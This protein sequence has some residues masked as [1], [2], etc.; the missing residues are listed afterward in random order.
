MIKNSYICKIK[1]ELLI[2]SSMFLFI[3]CH[4]FLSITILV[5]ICL[6]IWTAI[7]WDTWFHNPEEASYN[8]PDQPSWVLLTPGND[9]ELSRNVSWICGDTLAHSFLQLMG[10][11]I[12]DTLTIN[13]IGEVFESCS[14]KAAYYHARLDSLISGGHYIYSVV[15]GGTQSEWFY[16]QMPETD[17]EHFSFVYVGDVQDTIDVQANKFIKEAFSRNSDAEMLVCGGDLTERPT[18]SYW[19]ETFRDIDSIAQ[20]VPVLNITGNHDYLKGVICTLERRF[21]LVFSY[22]LHSKVDDNMVYTTTF[23]P[24]QFF[25][26]DSNREFFYLSKQKS[27]L[28]NELEASTS[29]WK[30]LLIHHPLQSAKGNNMIQKWMFDEL[31]ND[32]GIDLVLQAHEHCYARMT[33]KTERGTPTT[34]VYTISHCSPKSYR[35]DFDDKFDKFGISS[36]YYQTVKVHGDTLS[37]AAYEVYANNLYDSLDIIKHDGKSIRIVDYGKD[38][39]EHIEYDVDPSSSKSV[40]YKKK[41]DE[42]RERHPERF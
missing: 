19:C 23:G 31:V 35:I 7:K 10:D 39:K 17:A 6:A 1:D 37:V 36:R 32:Y 3:T 9:G 27:W 21:P 40:N 42:Y 12:H 22:F 20:H 34:P 30:I 26:L 8:A 14:G 28:E 13:A 25:V 5:I 29:K 4:K 16:F 11:S 18:Y 38:I 33:T 41:V 24:V 2:C 15:T